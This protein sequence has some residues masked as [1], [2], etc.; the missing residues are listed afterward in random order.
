MHP[1]RKPCRPCRVVGINESAGMIIAANG[2]CFFLP[3]QKVDL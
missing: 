3:K 1:G 2:F